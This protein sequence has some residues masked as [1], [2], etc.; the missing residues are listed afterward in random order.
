M[1]NIPLE[2]RVD[3]SLL[4][5]Q[6]VIVQPTLATMSHNLSYHQQNMLNTVTGCTILCPH[7]QIGE[8]AS[9]P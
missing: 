6:P 7:G 1:D 3:C 4:L 5:E 2:A 8:E 9:N